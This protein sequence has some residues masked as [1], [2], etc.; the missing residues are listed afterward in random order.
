MTKSYQTEVERLSAEVPATAELRLSA[1][2]QFEAQGLP[3]K[4]DEDWRYADLKSI[5]AKAPSLAKRSTETIAPLDGDFTAHVVYL[6]GHFD[7][8]QSDVAGLEGLLETQ[9]LDMANCAPSLDGFMALNSALMTVG[10]KN[11]VPAGI[12]ID[13][14]IFIHHALRDGSAKAAHSK[15]QLHVGAGAAVTIIEFF[16][17]DDSA[18]WSN[19]VFEVTLDEGAVFNHIRLI[20]SGADATFTGKVFV[21]AHEK[22]IY[23]SFNLLI[24]GVMTRNEEHLSI[25]GAGAYGQIDTVALTDS[26][27]NHDTLTTVNH[28]V[29]D[30][31]SD[32]LYR[33]VIAARGK[34]SYQGKVTVARDA[35]Q[36]LADQGCRA[37]LLDRTA[38]ANAKPELEIFAD[39]VK[40]SHGA[41]VGELDD[42][43]LFYL[44]ARGVAPKE[45]RALLIEAFIGEMF[46]RVE[47]EMLRDLLM[48]EARSVLKG[49]GN[50]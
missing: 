11:T 8:A 4:R 48:R 42:T 17:G 36:T 33:S 47:N 2:E 32:Q 27:Q 44:A 14:P 13:K 10:V 31:I 39:D 22:A 21:E 38:E 24:G 15:R 34:A 30:A 1:F 9:S 46:E 26:K 7:L 23:R 43:A 19:D 37:I 49:L 28:V 20:K 35:Q 6:N 5:T 12:Q 45:A 3:S 16:E 18:C 40:C 50:E 29:A 25:V 41:T